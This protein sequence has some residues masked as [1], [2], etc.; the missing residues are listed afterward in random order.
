V[1]KSTIISVRLIQYN[2]IRD[3]TSK[4]KEL[5]ER[6]LAELER[7]KKERFEKI[8]SMRRQIDGFSK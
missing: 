4:E 6:A 2:D 7:T 1:R 3:E 8:L 5:R